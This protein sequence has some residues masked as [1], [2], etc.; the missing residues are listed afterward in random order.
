VHVSALHLLNFRSYTEVQLELTA[1]VTCF[2][3]GNG[4]GKTN[5]VEAVGYLSSLSSHRVAADAPLIRRTADHALLRARVEHPGRSTLLEVDIAPGRG[6]RARVNRQELTRARDILGHLRCVIFAPEDLAIV[7]GDPGERRY[8]LDHLLTQRAPR[9]AGVRADVDRILKQRNS[10]LKSAG[11]ARRHTSI[12]ETLD[13]WDDHLATAAAELLRA[14]LDLVG[15]LR[16]HAAAAYADVA[17]DGGALGLTYDP[18]W[19]MTDETMTRDEIREAVANRLMERRSDEVDRGLTL[20]GPHRDDL[21]VTVGELPVRGYASHGE[22]WSAALSLRLAAYRMLS[23]EAAEGDDPVLILDDV[24]AELD[25]DRRRRLAH[26]VRTASQVL[27]T[28]AVDGDVPEI[29]SGQRFNVAGGE[30]HRASGPA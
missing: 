28:A 13:V 4:Q 17:P 6:T 24:F 11:G 27:V 18:S 29:L 22:S 20:T 19:P 3:G 9:L 2:V 23:A 14:R 26:H 16:P 12:H 10:L 25:A 7:K 5:L 8:F 21:T 30:V 15:A 1:G